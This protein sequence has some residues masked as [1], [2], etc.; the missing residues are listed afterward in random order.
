[1]SFH[2]F[3]ACENFFVLSLIFLWGI[4]S[5]TCLNWSGFLLAMTALLKARQRLLSPLFSSSLR[6]CL[7]SSLSCKS[8]FLFSCLCFMWPWLA[9]FV[10]LY[11]KTMNICV[12]CSRFSWR[13]GRFSSL[14]TS[15]CC[16][17]PKCCDW[18]GLIRLVKFVCSCHQTI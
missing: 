6:R 10:S 3:G 9:E 5:N 14:Y 4:S 1:M 17:P 12:V 13:W 8:L 18:E 2:C 15:E 16:R 11:F 7:S